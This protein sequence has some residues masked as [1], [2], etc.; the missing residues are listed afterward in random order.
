MVNACRDDLRRKQRGIRIGSRFS[1][2]GAEH[3]ESSET[4]SER[5]YTKQRLREAVDSLPT[6]QRECVILRYFMEL[7]TA[8]TASTLGNPEGTVKSHLHRAMGRLET[9]IGD[10]Q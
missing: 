9:L 7:S 10:L 8:E 3:S 2:V 6:Q 1:V 5:S 4:I